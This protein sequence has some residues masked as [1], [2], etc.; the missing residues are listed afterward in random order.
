MCA[1]TFNYASKYFRQSKATTTTTK[2]KRTFIINRI[3]CE[4]TF[5]DVHNEGQNDF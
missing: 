4:I 1:P 3:D 2:S 5:D